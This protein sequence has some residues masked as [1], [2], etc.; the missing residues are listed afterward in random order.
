V[1][2]LSID[3]ERHRERLRR[4]RRGARHGPALRDRWYRRGTL[5]HRLGRQ[6]R[7]RR[8]RHDHRQ[9]VRPRHPRSNQLFDPAL[10]LAT[11]L[12]EQLDVVRL[13]QMRTEQRESRQMNRPN[14]N[15]F[16]DQ[17]KPPR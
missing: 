10:G 14:R 11:R 6:R 16:E 12:I 7:G 8:H 9:H 1:S 2:R 3:R 5:G 15:A 4:Q 17:R 13:G